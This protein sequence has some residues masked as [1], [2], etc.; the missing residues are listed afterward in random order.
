MSRQL[1]GGH[2][3]GPDHLVLQDMAGVRTLVFFK[4]CP[5]RCKW[6]SNPENLQ[7]R[8]K[9]MYKRSACVDCGACVEVCPV[10]I[11]SISQV[12]GEHEVNQEIEC[13]GCR[14]C[15]EACAYG[16]L[17]ISGEVRT[18]SEIMEI[19]EEDRAFYDLSGGGGPLAGGD[20]LMQHDVVANPLMACKQDVESIQRLKLRDME[21]RKI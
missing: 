8:Y 21:E 15:E 2:P 7:K 19:I 20:P 5:L 6:C 12:T 9:V 3:D 17:S 10:G 14:K 16:A 13:I 4:G 11:H 18:I 1:S